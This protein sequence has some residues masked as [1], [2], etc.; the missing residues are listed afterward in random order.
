MAAVAVLGLIVAV[1]AAGLGAGLLALL[2][3]DFEEGDECGAPTADATATGIVLA[4]PGT[5]QLV[6][7]TEYGGPGDPSSGV[8]GSSGVNLL[9]QPDSYAE[10]GGDTFQ[11]ATAMGGLPYLT[12]LRITWGSRSAIAYKRDIGLGGGP[13]DGLPRVLDLWWE[14]AARLG[15]PYEDGLWS[16]PVRIERPPETGAANL[17]GQSTGGSP[18]LIEPTTAQQDPATCAPAAAGGVPLASGDRAQLLA[19]GLAAA[20]ADAPH[21]V[22]EIIAAGNQIVGKPYLYGG[23]HGLPLSEIAPA[24]D[25]SSS[26]E[27]LLYG[28]RPAAG[29]LRR[30]VGDAGVVRAA[31]SRTVGHVVRERG[32]RLHV[33]RWAAVGH[34]QRGGSGR[35]EHGNRLA[36]VD[37][38]RRR[39]RGPAS[40][41][42]VTGPRLC[43]ALLCALACAG[44]GQLG[45]PRP[46]RVPPPQSPVRTPRTRYPSKPP[47]PQTATGA[48]PTAIQAVRAFVTAYINWTARTVPADMRSLAD[49]STGQA[50]AAMTLAAAETAGDYELRRGGIANTRRRRSGGAAVGPPRPVRRR[51][52]RVDERDE[53]HRLSGPWPRVARRARHRP[54]TT[55]RRVGAQRLATRNLDRL[56]VRGQRDLDVPPGRVRVRAH[57]V[58][59]GDDPLRVLGVLHLGEGDVEL[60][61]DLKPRSSVVIRL[62]LLSIEASPTSL[63]S[64]RP[65]TP[66]A[67]SKHAAKPTANSCSGLVP[68]PSPPISLGNR[69]WTSSSPSVV[70]P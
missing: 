51:H 2:T 60:D 45:A 9:G 27:H 25:C 32:P 53:H 58:G 23:G 70:W 65:T 10:L 1:I 6:G 67:P 55:R 66:S 47:P 49:R 26:V 19:N 39:V 46:L 34:A 20:P 48:A 30:P 61:R 24:Y 22:R 37:P 21:A 8:I 31:R 13:I 14:L 35:R 68:P 28:A 42:A 52:A 16:G 11:T 59:L 40:G 57:L 5:G 64:R 3:N 50:R 62:T 12:P 29:G 44:C 15:I 69:S 63:R 43:V 33:R 7:A 41:G 18:A 36:P 4:P 38:K 54:A 56:P 17:L